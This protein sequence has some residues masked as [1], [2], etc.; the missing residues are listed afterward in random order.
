MNP[1][2][3]Y[4]VSDA[5]L[6]RL[7][8]LLRRRDEQ[9]RIIGTAMIEFELRRA[10]IVAQFID[11]PSAMHSRL[12]A[13]Q[14]QFDEMKEAVMRLIRASKVDAEQI[15]RVALQALG[16][17]PRS[18]AMT[19]DLDNGAVCEMKGDKWTPMLR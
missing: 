12:G 15:E 8:D 11:D 13:I 2:D 18:G 6:E 19:I 16:L 17:D 4:V 14:F 10:E 9:A 5:V 1:A 7:R 3:I